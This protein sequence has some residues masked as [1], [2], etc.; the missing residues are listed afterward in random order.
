MKL[1]FIEHCV[2]FGRADR[3]AQRRR[4]LL[5]PQISNGCIISAEIA[6]LNIVLLVL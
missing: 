6:E 5:A 2:V 1:A 4:C 3:R